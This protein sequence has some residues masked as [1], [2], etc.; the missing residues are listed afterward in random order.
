ME[1]EL[2]TAEE[3]L[4]GEVSEAEE[5]V[6]DVSYEL[7]SYGSDPEVE[8]LVARMRRGDIRVPTF[9]RAYVWRQPEASKFIESLLLGLPVPGVFFAVDPVTNKQIV[10]D[11]QQRL[12]TLQFFYDGYF[13]PQ[14]GKPTNRVFSLVKV[15]H[16][17][18]GKTYE[19]LN[20]A[21]RIR[22]DTSIIHATTVKQLKPLEDNTSL[23]HIFGRL[24]SGGRRLAD[25]ELRSALYHGRLIDLVGELNEH[26]NWRLAF[27][28][29]SARL[30]D[31]EM[32][33]RFFAFLED[34]DS[35]QRPM[36]E[37]LSLFCAKNQNPDK[38]YSEHLSLSFCKTIDQFVSVISEK[39]FRLVTSFNVAVYDSCMVGMAR[40]LSDGSRPAPDSD[41]VL[42]SYRELIADERYREAVTRSTADASF[43]ERRLV[44]ATDAFAV[45]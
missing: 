39:P 36:S 34:Y 19:T 32:I 29:P 31:H 44:M 38:K 9:Q 7:A 20:A 27:G 43:V 28:A 23:Y 26:K 2:D 1:N 30:K 17:F 24:N 45:C 21:D 42:E 33:I 10:I 37:F 11:G 22:L 40:R 5:V 18:E 6:A 3:T 35:Y 4:E 12:K 13:N 14:L 8:G 15:Q 41:R 25:Q 16:Q